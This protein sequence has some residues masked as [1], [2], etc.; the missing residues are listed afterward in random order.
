MSSVLRQPLDL[1]PLSLV[2]PRLRVRLTWLG[3]RPVQWNITHVIPT[4][5]APKMT[6]RTPTTLRR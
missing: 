2:R 5:S 3:P 6:M 4:C 1:D